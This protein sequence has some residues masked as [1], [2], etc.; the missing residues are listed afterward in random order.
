MYRYFIDNKLAAPLD[1]FNRQPLNQ[2]DSQR[3]LQ[4]KE[5][6]SLTIKIGYLGD[7]FVRHTEQFTTLR[8]KSIGN[9]L[10]HMLTNVEYKGAQQSQKYIK[11][12]IEYDII[13]DDNT[14]LA[15][16]SLYDMDLELPLPLVPT[17]TRL[18]VNLIKASNAKMNS[19]VKALRL[20]AATRVHDTECN[21]MAIAYY[22]SMY[23]PRKVHVVA[24][25]VQ[26]PQTV[27]YNVELDIYFDINGVEIEALNY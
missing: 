4:Y 25:S 10:C 8:H 2:D 23:K 21:Y 16:R 5:T 11:D 13:L 12:I 6:Q 24:P 3:V 15:G 1:P 26:R 14:V 9:I 17:T 7:N 27:F 20:F 18:R 22:C 19:I